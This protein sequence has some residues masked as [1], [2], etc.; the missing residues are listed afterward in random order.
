MAMQRPSGPT[1]VSIPADDWDRTTLPV[2]PRKVARGFAPDPA[3]LAELADAIARSN[4]PVLVFGSAVDR[5][6]AFDLAVQLAERMNAPV[7]EAPTSS[8]AS[9]PEDHPLFAGFLPA[10]PERL[11]QLLAPHDLVVVIGA[12]VFTFHVPGDAAI[13]RSG[14]AIYQIIDDP[15]AAARA[16]NTTSILGAPALS[17]AAL[18]ALLAPATRARPNPRPAAP[19]VPARDPM[20]IEFVMLAIAQAT[21]PETIVVEE[22]PSHRPAMQRYLPIRRS[23]GF[24]TMASGG[25]GYGL[26][27][28]VGVALAQRRRVV[29]IIGDGSAMYSIQ[30][31]WTAVSYELPLTVLVLNNGGYGALKSF[32]RIMQSDNVPGMELPGI[33]FLALATAFGCKSIRVDRA[34]E[35]AE[36]LSAALREGGPMLVEIAVDPE[37]GAVY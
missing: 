36:V 30:A 13:F 35:L 17:L 2:A 19:P 32:G 6:G 11:S 15:A 31:L 14:A 4:N 27:A 5:D 8:R 22:A 24:Y 12:P 20:P 23:G 28:A 33:D 29:C 9:F 21:T 10:I 1:F 37:T 25:L 3:P 26:P 34:Q 18:L 7:W 16:P